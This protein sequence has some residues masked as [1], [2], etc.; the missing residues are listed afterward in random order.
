MAISK[1]N[2]PLVLAL[3]ALLAPGMTSANTPVSGAAFTTVNEAG[4]GTGYCQ[5]GKPRISGN[6]DEGKQYVWMKG[7]QR[8]A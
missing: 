6:I 7:G 5:N 2:D 3:L 4:D 8:G 1:V